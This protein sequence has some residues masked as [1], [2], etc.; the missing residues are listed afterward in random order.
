MKSKGYTKLWRGQTRCIMGDVKMANS[1]KPMNRCWFKFQQYSTVLITRSL[2]YLF[3]FFTSLLRFITVFLLYLIYI[4]FFLFKHS[5]IHRSYFL[6]RRPRFTRVLDKMKLKIAD[7]TW[8]YFSIVRSLIINKVI[9][10]SL[11]NF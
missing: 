11:G 1:K 10:T 4:F 8:H 2:F 9:M 5:L 3:I 7:L 6:S